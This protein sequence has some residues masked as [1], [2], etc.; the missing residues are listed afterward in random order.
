[1]KAKMLII[2]AFCCIA[3]VANSAPSDTSPSLEIVRLDTT[4]V[5]LVNYMGSKTG[6]VTVTV[7]DDAQ[8]LILIRSYRDVKDFSL[9]INF[10]SVPEGVYS[11]QI[12]NGI[13]KLNRTLNY[14][15]DISPTYSR[16]ENLGDGR[17]LLTSSHSGKEKITVRVYNESS[18]KVY[19]EEKVVRGD[20]SMLFNLKNIT[21]Q[22]YFEVSEKSGTFILVPG[23]PQIIVVKE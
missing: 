14:T 6:K 18:V 21:G 20:F 4:S 22:P 10:S 23:H 8:G 16:V 15:K 9:P 19:E 17:Y 12:D 11:I 2:A 13:E 3:G 5:Y 1:M 7:K